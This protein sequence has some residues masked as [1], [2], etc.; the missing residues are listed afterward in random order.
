VPDAVWEFSENAREAIVLAAR[1]S[2][3]GL[4][5][6]FGPWANQ[7]IA[8][9]FIVA[10]FAIA[11][12]DAFARWLTPPPPGRWLNPFPMNGLLSIALLILSV[13]VLRFSYLWLRYPDPAACKV[14]GYCLTGN[15]SGVCPECG[16]AF[17]ELTN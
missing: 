2:C 8:R 9:P 16:T 10:A 15:R 6:L 4:L 14:C 13:L 1:W 7:R 5:L 17:L 11:A 12:I 3:I